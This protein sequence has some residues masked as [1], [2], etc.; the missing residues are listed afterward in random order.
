VDTSGVDGIDKWCGLLK[1]EGFTDDRTF[2]YAGICVCK[3]GSDH[4]DCAAVDN[5]DTADRMR[6]ELQ[7]ALKYRDYINLKYCILF[8][9][10]YFRDG[11]VRVHTGT[12][13]SHLHTSVYGGIFNS[14]C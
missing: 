2:R 3:P 9:R 7:L 12:Y 4:K 13:H 11:S 5:F 8:D 1:S 10:I 14:A 6:A